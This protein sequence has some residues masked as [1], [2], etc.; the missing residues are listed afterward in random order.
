MFLKGV[1]TLFVWWTSESKQNNNRPGLGNQRQSHEEFANDSQKMY[2][3]L[4]ICRLRPFAFIVFTASRFLTAYYSSAD[5]W[6]ASFSHYSMLTLAVMVVIEI[7][8]YPVVRA[9]KLMSPC[10]I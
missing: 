1:C 6:T 10:G 7:D 3:T 8:H 4:F 9:T 5:Q 2:L